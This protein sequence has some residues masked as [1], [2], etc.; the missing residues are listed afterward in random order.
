VLFHARTVKS[1]TEGG[2]L[3]NPG[4]TFLVLF[5]H[6]LGLLF[7]EIELRERGKIN[8]IRFRLENRFGQ[9]II[10]KSIT[11]RTTHTLV[12]AAGIVSNFGWKLLLSQSAFIGMKKNVGVDERCAAETSR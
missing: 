3:W 9:S 4:K 12:Q 10:Y 1:V 11:S 6:E 7:K 5:T 8:G 2:C